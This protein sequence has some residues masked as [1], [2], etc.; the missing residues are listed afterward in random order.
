MTNGFEGPQNIICA[1]ESNVELRED[2]ADHGV[3]MFQL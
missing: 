2:V 3:A 1:T